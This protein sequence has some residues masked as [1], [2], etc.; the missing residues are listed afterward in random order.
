MKEQQCLKFVPL[1]DSFYADSRTN[2]SIPTWSLNNIKKIM[3]L[4]CVK[5]DDIPKLRCSY[6]AARHDNSV[7]VD[8]SE[9]D[10]DDE[11]EKDRKTGDLTP[12]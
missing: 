3:L 11:E 9:E 1:F 12:K 2:P 4:G 5:L 10:D 7:F 6:L 8:S